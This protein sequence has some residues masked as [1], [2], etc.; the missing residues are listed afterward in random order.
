MD[1]LVS[2]AIAQCKI[3]SI[4]CQHGGVCRIGGFGF[5]Q[6]QQNVG[7]KTEVLQDFFIGAHAVAEHFKLLT[8]DSGRYKTYFPTIKMICP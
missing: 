7:T 5:S 3:W 4:G 6:I 2:A 8:R 1:A